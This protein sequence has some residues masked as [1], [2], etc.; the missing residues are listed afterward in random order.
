[1]L[2]PRQLL[3][4]ANRL[5]TSADGRRRHRL[6]VNEEEEGHVSLHWLDHYREGHSGSPE[7]VTG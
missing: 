3:A 1:M 4:E 2:P 5:P 7:L 6:N